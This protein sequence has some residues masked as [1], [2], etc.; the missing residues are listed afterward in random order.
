MR[1]MLSCLWVHT[2]SQHYH[3]EVQANTKKLYKKPML[4]L[5]S[6][7]ETGLSHD[8]FLNSHLGLSSCWGRIMIYVEFLR[9]WPQNFAIVPESLAPHL[10]MVR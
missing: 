10:E 6:M 7:G 2:Y 3:L 8:I 1:Q 9:L 4:F 5:A